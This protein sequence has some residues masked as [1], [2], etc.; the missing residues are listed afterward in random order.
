MAWSVTNA[1]TYESWSTITTQEAG[2]TV[3]R[4]YVIA[5]GDQ[6]PGTTDTITCLQFS[7]YVDTTC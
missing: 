5:D 7:K 3:N 2:A 1:G 4:V 6:S